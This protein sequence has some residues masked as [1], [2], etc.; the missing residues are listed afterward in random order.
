MTARG[1][2]GSY[3]LSGVVPRP[4]ILEYCLLILTGAIVTVAV[5][6]SPYRGW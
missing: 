1:F 6:L 5:I 3:P 2:N 4:G